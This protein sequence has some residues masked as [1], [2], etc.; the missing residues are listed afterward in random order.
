MQNLGSAFTLNICSK[1]LIHRML[2]IQLFLIIPAQSVNSG[3]MQHICTGLLQLIL[4]Q[5][6]AK[7]N[8]LSCWKCS[9]ST[10]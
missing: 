6:K 3:Q 10:L 1:C 2:Q 4:N 7:T 8:N 9:I 5:K